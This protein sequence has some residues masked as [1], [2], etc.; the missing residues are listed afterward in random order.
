MRY[1]SLLAASAALLALAGCNN[2][3]ETINTIERDTNAP[4]TQLNATELPPAIT[5]SK[6]YRCADNSLFYVDFYNNNT[7]MVHRGSHD[8]TPTQL[9]GTSASGPFTAAGQ[10][11]SGTGNNVNI[12]GKAC[13]T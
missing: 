12:N 4:T 9:T 6:I 8:A 10:S 2:Q 3:P 1:T 13:H 11:V 5:A 7:A